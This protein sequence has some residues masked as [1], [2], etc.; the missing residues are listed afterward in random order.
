[1]A[2]VLLDT[3]ILIDALRGRNAVGRI[4]ALLD[5]GDAVYTSAINVEETVRGLRSSE[6]QAAQNLVDGMSIASIRRAEA[7]RA[8][9]WRREFAANGITLSQPDCLIAAAAVTV[10]ARLATGNPGD[11]PMDEIEVEHWPVGE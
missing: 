8:G 7:W 10:G 4:R 3:T 6:E 2:R 1:M 11:F 5:A 9:E